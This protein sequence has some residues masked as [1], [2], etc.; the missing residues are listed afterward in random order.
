ME[1]IN[2]YDKAGDEDPHQVTD[3][4]LEG[5]RLVQRTPLAMFNCPTRRPV[6][7][8]TL[9]RGTYIAENAARNFDEDNRVARSDYAINCGDQSNNEFSS[10][11]EISTVNFRDDDDDGPMLR[12]NSSTDFQWQVNK[13][14]PVRIT[15]I[16]FERSQITG[17]HIIDGASNTYMLGE[18]YLNADHYETGGDP[19]DN[20]G[21]CTGYNNDNFRNAHYSPMQDRPGYT[22][23]RLFGSV[24]TVG[25]NV[26]LCDGSVHTI[27]YGIDLDIHRRLANRRNGD[28]SGI[29]VG[30]L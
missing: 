2:L 30:D 16:S 25:F 14:N 7:I 5:A 27:G 10:G 24:H 6:D 22:N 18:K 28:G 13:P 1:Q 23:T 8:Y 9:R 26:A 19:S 20:E 21:W 17:A 29:E 11:P 4:Q 15:G 12:N 3:Q